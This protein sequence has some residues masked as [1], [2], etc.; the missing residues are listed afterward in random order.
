[1]QMNLFYTLHHF[2]ISH[3][4]TNRKQSEHQNQ[5]DGEGQRAVTLVAVVTIFAVGIELNDAHDQSKKFSFSSSFACSIG[6]LACANDGMRMFRL[7]WNV[8][9]FSV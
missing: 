2:D 9:F 3:H 1:M 8:R 4:T 5:N 6:F 7:S